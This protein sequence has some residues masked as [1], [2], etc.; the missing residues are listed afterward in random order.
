MSRGRSWCCWE[1]RRSASFRVSPRQTRSIFTTCHSRTAFLGAALWALVAAVTY[2]AIAPAQK[3]P[4]AA[5]V[6][7]AV[8]SHWILDLLVHRPDLALYDD[9]YKVGFGL[10]NYPALAFAL[11]IALLF[12]GIAIYLRTTEPR[13]SIGRYGMMIL[14]LVAVA[15]QA[16]VFFGPPPVSDTA[17]ALTALG[18]YFAFAAAAYWLDAKRTAIDRSQLNKAGP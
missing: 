3:W 10:W 7:G 1:S 6:G 8:F 13:D 9:T 11:E 17:F 15:L 14:G 16:Y 2:R 12:G 18:L 4:A 5:I